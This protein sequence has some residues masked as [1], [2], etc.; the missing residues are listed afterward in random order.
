MYE[1]FEHKA[2]VGVRGKGKTVEE[3]FCEVAKA[4]FSIQC[5]IKKVKPLKK[6]RILCKAQN[7]EELLVEWLNTLLAES[8]LR[9]M[10]FS[11]FEAKIKNNNLEGFAFGEKIKKKHELGTEVKAATYSELK[12]YK[13]NGEW[14][15]QCI[16]DV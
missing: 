5:N 14:I 9:G 12:V 13:K 1:T 3:A 16:V 7:V 2:D 6:V 15:A 11:E 8:S 10:L 4:M